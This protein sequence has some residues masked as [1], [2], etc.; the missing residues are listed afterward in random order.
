MK[1]RSFGLA[2]MLLFAASTSSAELP[3]IKGKPAIDT[4]SLLMWPRDRGDVM[5]NLDDPTSN[6]L[7]DLHGDLTH[8]DLLLSTE[9]NY[10]MALHD[11]WPSF[12]AQFKT[13]PLHNAFYT[14]SPPVALPQV[15]N[16]VLGFGNL[17]I[18]C[19][20]SLAVAS[21]KVIDK[22][23][24]AGMVEG[25]P[26]PLYRDRGDVILVKRGNPKHIRTVWDLGRPDVKLVTPNPALEPGA[27]EAYA[28]VIYG[29]ALNDPTPPKG[30]TAERLI[31]VIFN[32]QTGK[33]LAGARIH[34]RDV[35][36]SVAMGHA[37]AGL[38][39]YHLGKYT[40]E[41]FP[42]RFDSINLGGTPDQLS[43]G[44]TTSVRYIAKLKGNWNPVQEEAREVLVKS[45]LSDEFTRILNT[46]GLARP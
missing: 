39:L 42:Q 12:L 17:S 8:C 1:L 10:H 21:K 6:V 27:F 29:L 40:T 22:L 16:G 35:P 11:L 2:L 25:E 37:D 18:T 15:K 3:A 38:L 19:P 44:I 4:P 31:N 28:K 32:Q 33:W 20:P 36:W 7:F 5:P 46:R 24:A 13:R 34:H 14:T 43:E 23:V 9:G 41:T 30:W 45:L 26:I